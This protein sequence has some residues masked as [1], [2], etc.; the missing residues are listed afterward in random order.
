MTLIEQNLAAQDNIIPALAD[1]YAKYAATRK[2]VS[3]IMR[4]REMMLSALISSYDAYEDLI[5][6]SN[7]GLEFY[8]KLETNLTKL[9]QRVKGTCKVQQEERDTILAQH[10]KKIEPAVDA[11]PPSNSTPSEGSGLKLKDFLQNRKAQQPAAQS[12]FY[13]AQV[14]GVDGQ[15][16]WLP[17]VRPAPLGSEGTSTTKQLDYA[18]YCMGTSYGAYTQAYG[19]EYAKNY[20]N[21]SY[22]NPLTVELQNLQYPNLSVSGTNTAVNPMSTPSPKQYN[23]SNPYGYSQ[24]VAYNSSDPSNAIPVQYSAQPPAQYTTAQTASVQYNSGQPASAVSGLG[25]SNPSSVQQTY[26]ATQYQYPAVADPTQNYQN[27]PT[28]QTFAGSQ[29]YRNTD[30]QTYSTPGTPQN[31]PAAVTQSYQTSLSSQTSD[32]LT[33]QTPATQ[34]YNQVL[35]TENYQTPTTQSYQNPPAG[36]Y[37]MSPSQYYQS[38]AQNYQLPTTQSY[39]DSSNLN[40]QVQSNQG[41]QSVGQNS[42]SQQ[43]NPGATATQAQQ[44][45]SETT[46]QA[47]SSPVAGTTDQQNTLQTNLPYSGYSQNYQYAT[48]AQWPH[49]GYSY[50]ASGTTY[51]S[52]SGSQSYPGD[53]TVQ[54]NISYGSEQNMTSI[55]NS[56]NEGNVVYTPGTIP[57]SVVNQTTY[58][59]ERDYYKNIPAN[60]FSQYYPHYSN[61]YPKVQFQDTLGTGTSHYSNAG[62]KNTSE[63]NSS[64]VTPEGLT[65][66]TQY[67]ASTVPAEYQNYYTTPY[68]YQ[69]TMP[70]AGNTQPKTVVVQPPLMQPNSMT[71]IQASNSGMMVTTFSQQQ[72]GTQPTTPA[73]ETAKQPSNLDLLTGLDFTVTNTPPLKPVSTLNTSQN[74]LVEQSQEKMAD[75]SLE[76]KPAPS[77]QSTSCEI[78]SKNKQV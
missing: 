18:P 40:Y 66:A 12:S 33:Y 54:A 73:A 68:G 34:N 53:T 77:S 26:S 46:Q 4:Q 64:S 36:N 30:G 74:Q 2:A 8:R 72:N 32:K 31:Y 51:N 71:Y 3:E 59:N 49:Q 11:V 1:A 24:G 70:G 52:L 60:D 39:Q 63:T 55:S 78:D 16:T 75:L 69:Y 20:L 6:K 56:V 67:V 61:T 17:S 35:P 42:V 37:Q 38:P 29:P 19:P 47:Y 65:Y 23:T 76:P 45:S 14:A 21:Y 48:T 62:G 7:K 43:Q 41:Y 15:Q 57:T 58:P 25:S 44:Y 5:T 50:G 27:P 13:S 22:Q 28:T 10:N 9:L